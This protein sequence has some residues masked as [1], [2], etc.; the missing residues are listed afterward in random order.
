MGRAMNP[1]IE[2]ALM[3]AAQMDD[4]SN[5]P[6]SESPLTNLR[7][8]SDAVIQRI[9]DESQAKP[10]ALGLRHQLTQAQAQMRASMAPEERAAQMRLVADLQTRLGLEMA[11]MQKY[12]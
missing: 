2:L 6:D 4:F 3:Q 9:R 11:A 1:A 5:T 12:G 10:L 7:R 8:P